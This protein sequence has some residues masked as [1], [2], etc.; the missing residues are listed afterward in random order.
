MHKYGVGNN[1]GLP[2]PLNP[3]T[4]KINLISY[5]QVTKLA[6]LQNQV[7]SLF[8]A[9]SNLLDEFPSEIGTWASF[10]SPDGEDHK[11][12]EAAQGLG[13]SNSEDS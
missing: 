3:S 8:L 1:S 7:L 12:L 4:K 6:S 9:S 13:N 2:P 11:L 10:P 5:Q